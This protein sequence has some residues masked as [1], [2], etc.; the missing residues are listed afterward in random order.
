MAVAAGDIAVDGVVLGPVPSVHDAEALVVPCGSH[1]CLALGLVTTAAA[2]AAAVLKAAAGDGSQHDLFL[3]FSIGRFVRSLPGVAR[4]IHSSVRLAAV[5]NVEVRLI[6][7]DT[8]ALGASPD[9]LG[10]GTE[11]VVGNN[12]A[13]LQQGSAY[14]AGGSRKDGDGSVEEHG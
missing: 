7:L 8:G 4:L 14:G 13:R 10:D 9:V 1:I 2:G 6:A 11:G 3:V 5:G 12:S